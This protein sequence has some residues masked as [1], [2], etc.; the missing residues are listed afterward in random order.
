VFDYS[1]ALTPIF[2]AEWLRDKEASL[3]QVF[4]E[5][6]ND[7]RRELQAK[8]AEDLDEAL[9]TEALRINKVGNRALKEA[10]QRAE[11]AERN[12]EAERQ[13]ATVGLINNI[14][15]EI[16]TKVAIKRISAMRAGN[17]RRPQLDASSDDDGMYTDRPKPLSGQ[18]LAR[19]QQLMPQVD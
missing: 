12:L 4:T 16:L 2:K 19:P 14:L 5:R 17:D 1:Q 9:A 6:C 8:A 3:S 15:L 10:L 7:L 13:K 11:S 18:A